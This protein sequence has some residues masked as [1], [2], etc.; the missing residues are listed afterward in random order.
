[1]IRREFNASLDVVRRFCA[2]S[3]IT[4]P[5]RIENTVKTQ[6]KPKL[7]QDDFYSIIANQY[8]RFELQGIATIGPQPSILVGQLLKVVTRTSRTCL[9][10]RDDA[11]RE[12]K[13]AIRGQS[14]R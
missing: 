14:E 7:N 12:R 9:V 4:K 13:K 11:F 3:D 10:A 2:R 8:L 1:M 6:G 5:A